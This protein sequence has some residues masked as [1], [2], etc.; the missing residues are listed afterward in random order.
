[1]TGPAKKQKLIQSTFCP[2]DE[3]SQAYDQTRVPLGVSCMIGS[4]AMSKWPLGEQRLLDVG[5]GTGRFLQIVHSKFKDS[6]LFEVNDGMLSQAKARLGDRVAYQQGSANALAECFAWGAFHAVTMNQV[7]HHFPSEHNYAFLKEVFAQIYRVTAP[8]GTFVLNHC[9]H[10]QHQ[11][12]YWWFRFMPMACDK[13]C[14][15]SPPM[16]TCIKYMREVGFDVDE[17]EIYVPPLGLLMRDTYMKY[18]LEGAFMKSYRDGDSGWT[19]GEK[20]GELKTC[21]EKIRE[22]QHEGKE[23]EFIAQVEEERRIVGQATFITA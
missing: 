16:P 3:T 23:Q 2:Y 18:G 22:L 20:T 10:E 14:E 17:H 21:Q 15:S 4:L 1:M 11:K 8:G 19:V 12:A 13:Y 7:I 6:T 9:S 5:G